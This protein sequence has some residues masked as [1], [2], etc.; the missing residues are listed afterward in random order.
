MKVIAIDIY[1]NTVDI[2]VPIDG[3]GEAK[4]S[5]TPKRDLNEVVGELDY[6]SLHVPKQP[7]GEA[8]IGEKVLLNI[9]RF[10]YLVSVSKPLL[11]TIPKL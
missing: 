3:F 9:F 4:V 2:I 7:N 6:I 5:I 11:P 8:V 1:S 10:L